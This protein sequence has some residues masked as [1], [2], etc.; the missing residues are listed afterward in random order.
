MVAVGLGYIAF[1]D[2]ILGRSQGD[3]RKK[4]GG[5]LYIARALTGIQVSLND[6][7]CDCINWELAT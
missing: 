2:N 3:Q 5:N 7:R 1:E 4:A 6:L